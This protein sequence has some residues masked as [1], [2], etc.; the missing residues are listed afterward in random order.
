MIVIVLCGLVGVAEVRAT[1]A[2]CPLAMSMAAR[3]DLTLRRTEHIR[4]SAPWVITF[5]PQPEFH[6]PGR[7]DG[8]SL[9][10]YTICRDHRI[11]VAELHAYSILHEMYHGLDCEAGVWEESRIHWG[12]HAKG[13]HITEAKFNPEGITWK[14]GRI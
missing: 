10:A 12:W 14:E 8:A 5:K 1:P 4:L 6:D 7:T 2:F 3:A 13:R 9:R 11:F